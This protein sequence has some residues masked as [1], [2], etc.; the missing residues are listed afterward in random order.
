[1][2]L[3]CKGLLR[4]IFHQLF[5]LTIIFRICLIRLF[6]A[7]GKCI[8]F[9]ATPV[10]GNLG[11]YAIVEAQYKF[12]KDIKL[13]R[14][15]VELNRF[16]YERYREKLEKVIKAKD[17][18]IID[19]GGNIGTLWPEEE[20]KIRDIISRFPKNRIYIFP[21]TAYFEKT[22]HGQQEL[23][24]SKKVYNQHRRLNIFCRDIN[25]F[26]L[27]Q[28]NFKNV[29]SFYVPDIVTYI[30][31]KKT[32]KKKRS[33]VLLC[34][35]EDLE[36]TMDPDFL[37]IVLTYFK[38]KGTELERTST[39][40]ETRITK[41]NRKWKLR[42]KWQEFAQSEMV[43][44]DRLHGMIFSAITGTPCLA[45]DNLSHKVKEGYEWIKYL[46][47]IIFVSNEQVF[48]ESMEKI[49]SFYK[50]EYIYSN[51]VLQQEYGIMKEALKNDF[52]G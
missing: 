3:Y 18:I 32:R 26:E 16:E 37:T 42:K 36:R 33:G 12:F 13:K 5:F 22:E 1:M 43:I 28:S 8:F 50:R 40:L 31:Y 29:R 48:E 19:G 11:D 25:T 17:I 38:E 46:P 2:I 45:I 23:Q 52:F 10:Y 47:Y 15:I 49:L 34:M 41:R 21:Q 14:F 9:I 51:D 27:F 24:M 4:R 6:S 30:N 39:L 44:T 20:K 35:R 7:K